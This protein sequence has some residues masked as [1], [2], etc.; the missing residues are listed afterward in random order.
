M[1]AAS[2]YT[3]RHLHDIEATLSEALNAAFLIKSNAPLAFIGECLLRRA[4]SS[5]ESYAVHH[6]E[7]LESVLSD[8][9]DKTLCAEAPNRKTLSRTWVSS[10]SAPPRRV[11]G[12]RHQPPSPQPPSRRPRRR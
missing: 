5:E 6:A 1:E 4:T 9:V 10:S 8:A 3:Q 11:Q 12:C 2:E 7:A